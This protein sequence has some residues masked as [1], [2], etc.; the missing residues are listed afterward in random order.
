MADG[1][2]KVEWVDAGHEPACKANPDFPDGIDLDLSNGAGM[3]CSVDLPYP[4]PRVG[5]YVV[6]CALCGIRVAATT[7]GRRDDPRSLR[8][9]CRLMARS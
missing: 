8:I 3:T 2:F 9:A 1:R 7:A 6:T 5:V 4:A